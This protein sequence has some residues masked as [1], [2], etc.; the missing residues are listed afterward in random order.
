MAVSHFSRL[1]LT[2]HGD[3][4]VVGEV[5]DVGSRHS[6]GD[7]LMLEVDCIEWRKPWVVLH[8]L[9]YLEGIHLLSESNKLDD[10]TALALVFEITDFSS[11]KFS[12]TLCEVGNMSWTYLTEVKRVSNLKTR[13]NLL[14][15]IIDKKL[16]EK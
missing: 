13:V 5:L 8:C 3:I 6:L 9:H 1:A 7:R 14:R 10:R 4:V 2:E 15:Q 16:E 12:I 11:V